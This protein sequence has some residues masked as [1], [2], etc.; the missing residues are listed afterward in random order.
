MIAFLNMKVTKNATKY[1]CKSCNKYYSNKIDE[2]LKRRVKKTFKFS[3][4][5]INKFILLLRKGV[6]PSTWMNGKSLIKQHFLKKEEFYSNLNMEDITDADY[7][8]TKRVKTLKYKILEN[9][10]ICILKVHYFWVMVSKT[11]EKSG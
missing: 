3:N 4:N 9:T 11:S 6:Y 7:M 10:M 1:K 2:E 8:H 5:D